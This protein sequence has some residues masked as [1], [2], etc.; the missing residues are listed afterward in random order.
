MLIMVPRINKIA[1][2]YTNFGTIVFKT[3][4]VL[5]CY[6]KPRS[7]TDDLAVKW[8]YKN[9]TFVS[10]LVPKV[11]KLSPLSAFMLFFIKAF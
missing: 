1:V 9:G 3:S 4:D 2:N 7:H 10:L 5:T 8:L 6:G 11:S